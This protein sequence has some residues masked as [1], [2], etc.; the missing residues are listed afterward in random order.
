MK[1]IISIIMAL[2]L[3]FVFTAC[4]TESPADTTK[5]FLDSIKTQNGEKFASVYVYGG[6]DFNDLFSQTDEGIV[7]EVETKALDKMLDFD[8]TIKEEEI[9]D[10]TATVTVDMKC[11]ALGEAVEDAAQ[12]MYEKVFDE[13]GSRIFSGADISEEELNN[14]LGS[15]LLEKINALDEKTFEKTIQIDLLK[16]DNK[17][18]V[19]ALDENSEFYEAFGGGIFKALEN[20]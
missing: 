6:S 5:V 12:E 18:K 13:Y 19:A 16:E 7:G 17:W 11:Y 2:S 10:N 4:D 1:R 3:L 8:Y 9:N 15:I 20:V 14:F